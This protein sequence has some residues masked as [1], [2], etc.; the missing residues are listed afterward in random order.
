MEGDG[1]TLRKYSSILCFDH[2]GFHDE[3]LQSPSHPQYQSC[4]NL[5]DLSHSTFPFLE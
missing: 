2:G 3:G 5:V 1:H 4:Q